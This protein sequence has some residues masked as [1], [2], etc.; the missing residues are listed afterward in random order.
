LESAMATANRTGFS[1]EANYYLPVPE[2]EI[3][4]NPLINN[5]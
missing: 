5:N 4:A 3:N 2:E 1:G